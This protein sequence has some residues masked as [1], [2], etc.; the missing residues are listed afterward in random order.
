MENYI[1]VLTA[2]G[3]PLAPCH[4]KRAHSLVKQGKA[5][6]RHRR[7]VR[8]I[9]LNKTSV[10]K[11]KNSSKLQLRINPSSRHTGVAVTRDYSDGSRVEPTAVF[12]RV[13]KLQAFQD[14]S[15]LRHRKVSYNDAMRWVFRLSRTTRT[16]G[17]RDRPHP[18]ATASGERSI[19]WCAAR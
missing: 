18:P 11:I 14:A 3:R 15:S 4:P 7:G 2:S 19:A 17:R 10:P 12:G 16:A 6:Y 5:Q 13:V 8:C 1:P 9:M